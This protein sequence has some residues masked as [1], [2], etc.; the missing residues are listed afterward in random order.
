MKKIN[1]YLALLLALAMLLALTACGGQT[2]APAASTAESA[3]EAPAQ[4]AP[5]EE[6]P[7]EEA[8]AEEA[9]AEEAPA[10]EAPAEEAPAEEASAEEALTEEAPEEARPVVEYPLFDDLHTYTIWL[11][12]APDLND[13][14]KNMEEFVIF[15]ELEKVTNV[16]WN[17]TMVS[18]MVESEQFQ[19]MVASGDFT[20][21]VCKAV[22]N[23]NGTV[24]QAIEEDF[25]ID[26]SPYIDTCMPNLLGWFEKYPDLRKELTT[27]NGAI[28]GFP[29][30]YAAPSDVSAGPQIRADW[31]KDLGLE[32]PK[33]FDELYNVLN[34]FRDEKGAD[35][36]LMIANSSGVQPELLAGYNI[37]A[38]FYQVDGEI[39]YGAVQPEF[40]EYLTMMNKWFSE[41]LINDY[42]LTNPYESLMDFT[43]VLNDKAGVWYCT[44]AQMMPYLISSAVDPN[45]SIT[46]VTAVTKDGSKAH[47]GEVGSLL[48]TQ[49]WSITPVCEDP[50]V[51]AKYVDYVYSEDGVLLANYGVEG[52]TFEYV[53]G[54]PKLTDFVL[55]NP[56]YS[57][58]AAMNI[59]VCD[60]MTPAPFV[61]DEDR[62]RAD[63]VEDQLNAIAVWNDSNDNL[64]NLPRAGISMN[65]QESQQYY[66]LYSD[67][68][69]YEDE[70]IVKFIVGDK[71]LDEF[72]DFVATLKQMG[73]DQCVELE[74]AAYDRYLES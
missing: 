19:L 38:G 27:D 71:S 53:D 33:T 8:P 12:T 36:P 68:E 34:T 18:F 49:M 9:P 65:V 26:L 47:I 63:Y 25:L 11:G 59:F 4:E 43:P 74:Q 67:I 44:A 7:A 28:G 6:A 30:I 16:T 73:V 69:T 2:A 51:I 61:I 62:V 5:V 35:T 17:A 29:K 20:D 32:N 50:D 42:F 52:E 1:K 48:D 55:N 56:D 22:D 31:L 66:G 72:D 58:G 14:V 40:K 39:R 60:R 24:D 10:E 70:N 21:V 45:F 57:Y 15:R 41:G 64:Y 3:A 13:V 37:N 54:T 46:G 23:Y